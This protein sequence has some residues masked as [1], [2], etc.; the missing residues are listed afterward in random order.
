MLL[1]R[2]WVHYKV[3]KGAFVGFF[4]NM[5]NA[6]GYYITSPTNILISKLN[7]LRAF[8]VSVYDFV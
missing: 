7:L 4:L 2:Y 5:T 1:D 6:R 3:A 8:E